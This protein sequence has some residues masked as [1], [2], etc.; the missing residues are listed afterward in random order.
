M[1]EIRFHGGTPIENKRGNFRIQSRW[2]GRT[3]ALVEEPMEWEETPL[4]VSQPS[5]TEVSPSV[6]KSQQPKVLAEGTSV[7]SKKAD[8]PPMESPPTPWAPRPAASPS[9]PPPGRASSH[10][11]GSGSENKISPKH[12]ISEP[13]SIKIKLPQG[14]TISL[15]IN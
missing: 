3:H 2:S 12:A 8:L 6:S 14:L 7:S 4:E 9:A 5:P 13:I 11:I 1:S 15:L 10:S